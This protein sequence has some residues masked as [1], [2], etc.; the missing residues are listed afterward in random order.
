[1]TLVVEFDAEYRL[2]RSRVAE[3]KIDVL[4]INLVGVNAK[5]ALVVR[6]F[7]PEDIGERDFAVEPSA[8]SDC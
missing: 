3:Q 7:D 2:H 1:M 4:A 5:A 8:T 6:R